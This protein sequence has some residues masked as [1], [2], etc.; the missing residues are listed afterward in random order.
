MLQRGLF[1]IPSFE[2]YK[3]VKGL[4]DFGPPACALKA[5]VLNLWRKHFVL[6][7]NMLEI[8]CTNMTPECVLKTS[9][10]V[11]KFSDFMVKDV[12]NGECYRADKLLEGHIDNLLKDITLTQAAR[13]DLEKVRIQAG[14]Y[15]QEEIGNVIKDMGVV[16]PATGSPLSDPFPF[17]LMFKTTIGPEGNA[18]GFLRPET[19]QGIFVNFR[20]LYDYNA[21]KMPF[22]CAQIGP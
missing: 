13:A 1:V 16:S 14:A 7:D 19:A 15:S 3:G 21:T 5:N 18:V 2:I 17:N 11:D 6:E 20:R 12:S 22:A 9:G 10:H 4:Y 8:E